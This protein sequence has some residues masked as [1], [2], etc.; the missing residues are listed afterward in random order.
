VLL[1]L[2]KDL[3]LEPY[4]KITAKKNFPL[5]QRAERNEKQPEEEREGKRPISCNVNEFK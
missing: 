3:S 1:L 4:T 5:T 2:Q